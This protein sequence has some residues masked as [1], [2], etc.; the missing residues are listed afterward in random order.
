MLEHTQNQKNIKVVV[1]RVYRT[2]TCSCDKIHICV[3]V[4]VKL[5]FFFFIVAHCLRAFF[6]FFCLHQCIIYPNSSFLFSFRRRNAAIFYIVRGV[7]FDVAM[8][9]HATS[10]KATPAALQLNAT[11]QRRQN[12]MSGS[13]TL[14]YSNV[15]QHTDPILFA[16]YL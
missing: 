7:I 2:K 15:Q 4:L 12:R 10:N 6:F 11:K 16:A 9:C 14:F 5:A 8:Q 13:V 3:R 1:S